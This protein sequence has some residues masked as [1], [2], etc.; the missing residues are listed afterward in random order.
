MRKTSGATGRSQ[1]G[2]FSHKPGSCKE[3][4]LGLPS[5]AKSDAVFGMHLPRK[6]K[7]AE[8]FQMAPMID[9]VFLLL[10]F[11]MCVSTL[12]QADRL[13]VELDLPE[14]TESEVPEDLS[15]RGTISLRAD[16]TL[17]LRGAERSPAE[18]EESVRELLRSEPGLRVHL[19]A[20][21]DTPFEAVRRVLAAC[22]EA[23]AADV[24]YATY[25]AE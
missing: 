9:M 20:D 10:V 7:E 19:R 25:Q 23:G 21:R 15:G 24:I 3:R 12:A 4:T 6:A 14:S 1:S 13:L 18:V 11:F 22:A 8:D 2:Y 17:Y 5:S 16:G